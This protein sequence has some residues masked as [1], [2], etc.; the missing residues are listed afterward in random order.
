MLYIRIQLPASLT[1]S[2]LLLS[3]NIRDA[4]AGIHYSAIRWRIF[5][6]ETLLPAHNVPGYRKDKSCT[7][8]GRFQSSYW[9]SFSATASDWFPSWSSS[10][11]SVSSFICFLYLR[12]P[13]SLL[14]WLAQFFPHHSSFI[15][16]Q[17]PVNSKPIS[18]TFFAVLCGYCSRGYETPARWW[19]CL[20]AL[21]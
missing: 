14:S 8:S 2:W 5:H 20:G 18:E 15:V 11:I 10:A 17:R 9:S 4:S 1:L 3:T 13:Y 7:H 21:P 12:R 6:S 19:L 16:S